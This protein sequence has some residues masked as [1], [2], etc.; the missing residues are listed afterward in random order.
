[1]RIDLL[2]LAGPGAVCPALAGIGAVPPLMP[3]TISWRRAYDSTVLLS[4]GDL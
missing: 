3:T 4:G 1:M 2:P